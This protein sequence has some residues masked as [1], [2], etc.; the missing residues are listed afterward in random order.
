MSQTLTPINGGVQEI[1][2][3]PRQQ[4]LKVL[5]SQY[6][7][8]KHLESRPTEWTAEGRPI[9]RRL[10][11]ASDTYQINFF[12]ILPAT[13]TAIRSDQTVDT[14][15][16]YIPWGEGIFGPISLEVVS[17]ESK[18]DLIIKA[19]QVVWKYG[20][21]PV[22]PAL[23][24][25]REV[26]IG[27]GKY[28]VAYQ[29]IYDDTDVENYYS[30]EDYSLAG[31][32]LVIESSSDSTI[33]WRFEAIN[34]FQNNSTNY[35][36]NKDNYFPTYAQP[37]SCYIQWKSNDFFQSS[38][39][40]PSIA[41][42]SAFSKITLRCPSGTGVSGTAILN[43]IQDSVVSFVSEVS[44]QSDAD[45]QFYEFSISQ[46]SFQSGWK[47]EFSDLNVKIQSIAVSGIVA[48]ATR[49]A[50]PTTRCALSIYPADSIPSTIV[51]SKGEDVPT[52]FC[53]LAYIDVDQNYFLTD[54]SDI[55][56]IIHRDY[57]PVADW[58]TRP[59]DED[60]IGLYEQV[61]GYSTLWMSPTE[62][63]VQEYTSLAKYDVE[64]V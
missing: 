53:K 20:T 19:G 12:D 17:S 1:Q 63:M 64:L 60:L 61:K 4:R 33:G 45:G 2:T 30:V 16:V 56:P 37:S 59:F 14:G 52:V 40:D 22:P 38:L 31:T 7:R 27:S 29:L 5:S 34:A 15:Y 18:E 62:S 54:I 11:G 32:P 24:N 26:E 3:A 43:Y 44:V 23:V 49:Q 28:L 42:P 8:T 55:R 51:N 21:T 35:W 9:Y 48:K 57:K 39:T 10:P 58:L 36:S 47:V 6:I 25:L 13:N 41:L 50:E 46:P